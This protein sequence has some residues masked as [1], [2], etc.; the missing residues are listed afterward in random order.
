[1]SVNPTM[2]ERLVHRCQ[3]VSSAISLLPRSVEHQ[4]PNA[5]DLLI[6]ARQVIC[7]GVGKSGAVATKFVSTL[8]SLRFM[9]RSMNVVDLHHGDAGVVSSQ[10]VVVLISKSGE[11]AET[12][13]A[14]SALR[15]LEAKTIA[16]TM[17]KR[18]R[19]AELC[20]VALVIPEIDELDD[21]RLLP[22]TSVVAML[23]LCDLLALEMLSQTNTSSHEQLRSSHPLGSIGT[24]LGRF[25]EDVMHQGL[26]APFV[27]QDA[28]LG[29]ALIVMSTTSL[30]IVCVVDPNQHLLGIL[31]DGDVR[32]LA[33]SNRL[34]LSEPVIS[35][36]TSNPIVI[37]AS[38]TL[39][40][41]LR[42]MEQPNRQLSALPVVK[43]ALCKG[44]IRLHD[45][46]RL[47][48]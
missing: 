3:T 39:H 13:K 36:V 2:S 20:D 1:M 7:L 4:M 31:T 29:E 42:L 16:I 33:A 14:C 10:D 21:D 15:A 5:V 30:G 24:V 18:S 9:A 37:D 6:S 26:A 41:A 45:I 11:T 43:G 28:T 40:E 46:A 35:V 19:L 17:N 27:A 48:V 22:T 12:L 38:S 8:M 34:N 23:V 44:V 25:V 47:Q 32:R